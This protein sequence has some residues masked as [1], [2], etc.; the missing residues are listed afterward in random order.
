MIGCGTS[1]APFL[2]DMIATYAPKGTK[3]DV[4]P[5][6]NHYFGTSV[7]VTGL[8]TGQ[9]LVAQLKDVPCDEYMISRSMLRAQGDLFLDDL[10]L[11]DVQS[12]LPAPLKVVDN[13]GEAFW[14]AICGMEE[15]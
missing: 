7:T 2:R 11:E 13:T 4:V 9:D 5:I 15:T 10:T 14:L 3:I 6:Q 8:I 1:V 12:Q